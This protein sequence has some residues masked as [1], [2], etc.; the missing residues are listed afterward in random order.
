MDVDDDNSVDK[1]KAVNPPSGSTSSAVPSTN[2]VENRKTNSVKEHTQNLHFHKTKEGSSL[3]PKVCFFCE[4]DGHSYI[5]CNR[6]PVNA[7][8]CFISPIEKFPAC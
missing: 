5:T 2:T 4:E 3:G 1:G 8:R 6:N 7:C